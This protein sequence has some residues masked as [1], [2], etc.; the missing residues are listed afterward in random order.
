MGIPTAIVP[1]PPRQVLETLPR[2]TDFPPRPKPQALSDAA[3]QVK[4]NIEDLQLELERLTQERDTLHNEARVLAVQLQD[5][6]ADLVDVREERD[7]YQRQ[8][9]RIE[10]VA[11]GIGAQVLRLMDEMKADKPPAPVDEQKLEQAA[12]G[13]AA[14]SETAGA[15]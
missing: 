2:V 5:T 11:E 13:V 3:A 1:K 6:R 10:A 12:A 4:Q 8:V 9:D 15:R 14:E 7:R